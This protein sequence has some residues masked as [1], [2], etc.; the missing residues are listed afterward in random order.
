MGNKKALQIATKEL[1]KAKAPSKPKDIIYD[2]AG[3]WKFPGQNTRI[4]SGDITMQ[5]VPY[6]VYGEP[7]VGQPQMMYP[8]QDY[9]FPGADYVDEYPQMRRGGGI[10]KYL[11]LPKNYGRRQYSNNISATNRLFAKNFLFRKEKNKIYDPNAKY[12]D[13]GESGC[14]PGYYW[15][16][17]ECVKSFIP[18]AKE[19]PKSIV[20]N[21]KEQEL[22][23]YGKKTLP[24][25]KSVDRSVK[26]IPFYGD[27]SEFA[28]PDDLQENIVEFIDPTGFFSWDDAYRANATRVKSGSTLPTVGQALDMFG[29]VPGLGKLGKLKYLKNASAIKNSMKYVAPAFGV[30]P[31]QSI[32]NA[33]DTGQDINQDN[34]KYQDGGEQGCPEGYA[35]N[36]KTGECIEWNP[37]I[38]ESYDQ[39][40]SFDPVGDVI[41]MNP[42]DRPEGMSDEK[43]AQMYQDQLE[44]EQLH[45]LQWKN[46]ELKGESKTPLRMPSTVD[47]E[48]FG[49]DHYYN[50]RNEEV[51][52]LHDYWKNHHPDE[53][54][55]IPD[56]IIY[57][58]ETDPAM[59]QLPWTLEGEARGYEYATHD[60]MESLFPKK[61][62]GGVPQFAPGG[63]AGCP[64]GSYWN[65]KECVKVPKGAKV[66]TDPKEYA[67]RKGAYEDSLVLYNSTKD[68]IANLKNLEKRYA[69][70]KDK[71]SKK[72]FA[73]EWFNY[74]QY[75]YDE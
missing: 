26:N 7:N 43:Y 57:N 50:R 66:I 41:N 32:L 47:N 5:G 37:D 36:P 1:N 11:K 52:Y 46:D 17:K 72:L 51:N 25:K 29:V 21:K 3:Q 74:A 69:N 18:V 71:A 20:K 38:R 10:P 65:G 12:A 35:F 67:R 6:P 75:W 44:H 28:Q 56:D 62:Y 58:Y 15:N 45:R 16:G 33:V 9:A 48:D 4:P 59:Y 55:F 27:M 73:K 14:K 61:A 49:G 60:G 40:T 23:D 70:S 31:W 2:P 19:T 54:A 39:P 63:S 34:A 42:D 22:I 13:G 30:I 53:A 24:N 8:G 68:D 64:P